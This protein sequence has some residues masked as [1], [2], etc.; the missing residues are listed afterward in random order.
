MTNHA[1]LTTVHTLI[2]HYYFWGNVPNYTKQPLKYHIFLNS[3]EC[4]P[5]QS[6]SIICLFNNANTSKHEHNSL[7]RLSLS[8]FL[9]CACLTRQ[10]MPNTY[11]QLN[12]VVFGTASGHCPLGQL[13]GLNLQT[14]CLICKE[15]K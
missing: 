9:F 14:M 4:P 2:D 8:P 11:W 3:E 10:L 13:V 5:T 7:G 6:P 12:L 15:A 1:V